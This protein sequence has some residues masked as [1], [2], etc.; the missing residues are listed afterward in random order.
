MNSSSEQCND[1]KVSIENDKL[2][3]EIPPNEEEGKFNNPASYW[4]SDVDE[5]IDEYPH[6]SASDWDSDGD[7]TIDEY[8]DNPASDWDSDEYTYTLAS[9]QDSVYD[10]NVDEHPDEPQVTLTLD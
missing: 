7:E 9:Y 6:T 5:I 3:L 1:V 4:D 8:P 2:P 10:L